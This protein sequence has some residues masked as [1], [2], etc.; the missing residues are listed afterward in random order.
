MSGHL[1]AP[2]GVNS[3]N[4]NKFFVSQNKVAASSNVNINNKPGKNL[5]TAKKNL[6]K[7]GGSIVPNLFPGAPSTSGT[8]KNGIGRDLNPLTNFSSS[9]SIGK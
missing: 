7:T 3:K 4:G 5:S 6:S 8:K 9:T 1:Y 2:R